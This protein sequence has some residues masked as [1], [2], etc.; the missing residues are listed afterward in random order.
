M[1]LIRQTVSVARKDLNSSVTDPWL[2]NGKHLQ[3]VHDTEVQYFL[4]DRH[5]GQQCPQNPD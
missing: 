2:Y 4:Q 3:V 1:G 5:T